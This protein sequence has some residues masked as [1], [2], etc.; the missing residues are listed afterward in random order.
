MKDQPGDYH[1]HI[2]PLASDVP[3]RVR[4]RRLLKYAL[5]QCGFRC[6]FPVEEISCEPP[7]DPAR[8]PPRNGE[9]A[10]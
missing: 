1:L 10:P 2:R 8:T 6:L 4:L 3:A 5:R 7:A 9:E